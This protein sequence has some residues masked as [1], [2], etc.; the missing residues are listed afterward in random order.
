MKGV[1]D[2]Y[3][4]LI[5]LAGCLILLFILSLLSEGYFGGADNINH[6]FISHYA[7]KYPLLF[8]NSWG[9][10]LYTILSSPFAQFGF[11]G[12]VLFN[13]F[14]GILTAFIAYR[15]VKKLEITPPVLIILFVCFT[16]LYCIMLL[17]SLT[18]ILFGFVLVLAIY[19]FFQKKYVLSSV[20]ISF[21]PFARSEG[22]ILL[23]IFFLAYLLKKEFKA[24]PFLLSGFLFF[25]LTGC[26]FY[27]DLLWV[28]HKF[29]YVK[30]HSVYLET[31]P[32]LYF[33]NKR[34]FIFGLPYQILFLFGLSGLILRF[35]SKDKHLKVKAF[36]EFLLIL[37]PFV[38]YFIFHSFLF[39]K[40]I[41]GSVGEIRVMAGILPLS[42]II[43]L[44]GYQMIDVVFLRER[45][46]KLLFAIVVISWCL[47]TNFTVFQ[48]PVNLGPEETII[49]QA[50]SWVQSRNFS[51]KPVYFTDLNSCFFLGL[52]PYDTKQSFQLWT[53]RYL[54]FIPDSSIL[55]W[56][57]HFGPNESK[58]SLD[59]LNLNA[60]F[61]LLKIFKPPSERKT[62]GGHSYEVDIFMKLPVTEV[63]F[64][65]AIRDSILAR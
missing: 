37:L 16:P 57:A 49:K 31:G 60:H 42:A 47:F 35:F 36:Y 13:V 3:L 56:D 21:L 54:D 26:F 43:C 29:P 17:T 18:E 30:K 64:N 63:S 40:G 52:D 38:I 32:L 5:V 27:K 45:W 9:R 25:S 11:H 1:F 6:Y 51:K 23:I 10:P 61:K 39:W 48:Y 53:P 58:I 14:L 7:F 28:I 65:L 62:Y 50:T 41:G 12:A 55:I 24:I 22:F 4:Y 15:V 34:Q 19:F 59:S 44:M 2:K 8:L 46:R 20:I 33:F